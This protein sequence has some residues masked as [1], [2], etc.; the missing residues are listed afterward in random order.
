[1][2]A[3]RLDQYRLQNVALPAV[4]PSKATSAPQTST[5][6]LR[7][8]KATRARF[9]QVAVQVVE[10]NSKSS[11]SSSSKPRRRRATRRPRTAASRVLLTR[12]GCGLLGLALRGRR[13]PRLQVVSTAWLASRNSVNFCALAVL[14]RWHSSRAQMAFTLRGRKFCALRVGDECG[15]R[16]GRLSRLT[17]HKGSVF[18]S[19]ISGLL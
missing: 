19:L 1:M 18:A 17:A 3:G 15:R 14:L 9:L 2:G 10:N 5:A 7:Y 16:T 4:R 6:S 13:P 8:R 12:A 11:S